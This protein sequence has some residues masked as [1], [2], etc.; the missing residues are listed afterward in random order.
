MYMCEETEG[1]G[2]KVCQVKIY[3]CM[4]GYSYERVIHAWEKA[5]GKGLNIKYLPEIAGF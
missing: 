1:G 3:T 2:V 4:E 5:I